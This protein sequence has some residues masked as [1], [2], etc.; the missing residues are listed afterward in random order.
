MRTK[1]LEEYSTDRNSI[2]IGDNGYFY[3]T[4]GPDKLNKKSRRVRSGSGKLYSRFRIE[5]KTVELDIHTQVAK[6]FVLN[7]NGYTNVLFKDNDITNI[8]Y[9]NLYWSSNNGMDYNKFAEKKA[10]MLYKRFTGSVVGDYK[11]I[12]EDS[13]SLYMKCSSCNIDKIVSRSYIN[14]GKGVCNNCKDRS[15][16]IPSLESKQLYNWVVIGENG[17]EKLPNSEKSI[18]VECKCCKQKNT[19]SYQSFLNRKTNLYCNTLREKR[20]ILKSRIKNIKSRCYNKNSKDYVRY[21]GRG[22]TVCDEWLSNSESFIKWA[23]D[24]DF[25]K[26]LEF[27]RKNNDGPYSPD[28]C[29]L[30]NREDHREKHK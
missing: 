15:L 17:T 26:G 30:L 14:S 16:D 9:L 28:N 2:Y 22:I 5:G 25:N 19:I 23:L 18:I 29:Q 3:T 10:G 8:S 12:S 20:K 13:D 6:A 24:N 21:G 27:D 11:V 4:F 7:N 1:Y